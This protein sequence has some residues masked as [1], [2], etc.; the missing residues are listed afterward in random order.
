MQSKEIVFNNE[1]LRGVVGSTAHGL[2]INGQDDR[3]EM[4]IFVEPE[5]YVC[6]LMSLDHYIYR[7]KPEG[8]RSGPGDLDLTMYSLRKFC[9]LAEQGNPSILMLMWLPK[10]I[11]KAPI[12][13][14]LIAI[15]EDFVSADAGKRFLGYLTSQR[16]KMMGLKAHTVKRPELVEMYGYDTKFAMHAM[17][18]GL[19]GIELMKSC[20]LVLPI[21]EPHLSGLRAIRTGKFT[22]EQ[23]QKMIMDTEMELTELVN[24]CTWET[25][26][27]GI[28][29]FLVNA[30]IDHWTDMASRKQQKG[31]QGWLNPTGQ[32]AAGNKRLG[33]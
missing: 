33:E 19:Q 15:R 16:M 6:G 11:T 26:K 3:D 2:E 24:E 12:A 14:K 21:T 25:N 10:F 1:I 18:L 32:V 5:E 20:Y 28:N 31:P 22:F 27:A 29:N 30:H 9:R 13:A 4:G 23:V 8:V 17:R 7:D